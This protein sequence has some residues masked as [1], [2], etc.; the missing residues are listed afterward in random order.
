MNL[1]YTYTGANKRD[2]R[3]P[4]YHYDWKRD[5]ITNLVFANSAWV[6]TIY[7]LLQ[8]TTSDLQEEENLLLESW[9]ERSLSKSEEIFGTSMQCLRFAHHLRK[10]FSLC[11]VA[12]L[13]TA[14]FSFL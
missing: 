8:L 2:Y 3:Q 6:L 1:L 5:S 7:S 14:E 13:T 9:R 11:C 12:L 10:A 4:I